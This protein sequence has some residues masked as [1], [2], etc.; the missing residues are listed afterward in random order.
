MRSWPALSVAPIDGWLWR[1]ASGGSLRANSVATLAYTGRDLEGAI[2][3]AEGHYRVRGAASRFTITPVSEPA[4][5]DDLLAARG[6]AQGDEHVTMLKPVAHRPAAPPEVSLSSEPER[7]WLAVYLAGLTADRVTVAPSI[8]ERL[9]PRRVFL[10]CRRAGEVV[11][12]GLCV[13]DGRVASVQCMAT[14]ADQRRRGCARA[15]LAAIEAWAAGQGCTHLY[16]QAERANRPA[17]ALYASF[18]FGIAGTYHVRQK[19]AP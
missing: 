19:R 13:A 15:V 6:Y 8:L 1:Y 7:G 16:L 9:P 14:S 11:G 4:G 5:L 12:S 18:G 17:I 3:R 10:A 2:A